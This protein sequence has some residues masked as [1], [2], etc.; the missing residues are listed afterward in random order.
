MI[1]SVGNKGLGS[2]GYK[3][4]CLQYYVHDY[5]YLFIKHVYAGSSMCTH[6]FEYTRACLDL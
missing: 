6:T 2:K 3:M 5:S 1:S 4:R